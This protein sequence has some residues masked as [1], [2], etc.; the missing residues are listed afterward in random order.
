MNNNK[1][2]TINLK[3]YINSLSI[4]STSHKDI[5]TYINKDNVLE[6]TLESLELD[7]DK[8]NRLITNGIRD[9]DRFILESISFLNNVSL[10]EGNIFTKIIEGAKKIIKIILD[11]IVQ[12]FRWIGSLFKR[13]WNWITRKTK[14]EN[15]VKK[16]K[17]EKLIIFFRDKNYDTI[18][19]G[20]IEVGPNKLHNW[21]NLG[22]L[23]GLFTELQRR[24]A[25]KLNGREKKINEWSMH[26][27]KMITEYGE[28]IKKV[29]NGSI[30]IDEIKNVWIKRGD[31][32]V[33]E[34]KFQEYEKIFGKEKIK[35]I[36]YFA[37]LN[38]S[39]SFM[40]T[41]QVNEEIANAYEAYGDLFE[42]LGIDIEEWEENNFHLPKDFQKTFLTKFFYKNGKEFFDE[43]ILEL[44][45]VLTPQNI[46]FFEEYM[47]WLK[48]I[49]SIT[50]TMGPGLQTMMSSIET[51][52][53]Q[54]IRMKSALDEFLKKIETWDGKNHIM[55]QGNSFA[56]TRRSFVYDDLTVKDK[57][58]IVR[59]VTGET[60]AISYL[61]GIGIVMKQLFISYW[62]ALI[63]VLS[64]LDH[65]LLWIFTM[66]ELEAHRQ[67]IIDN[68]DWK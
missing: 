48:E 41:I 63:D 47:T 64:L 3:Q 16:K 54:I 29:S 38:A 7:I 33:Y 15:V 53:Q 49:E 59:N 56:D 35:S 67:E 9:N 61:L 10:E 2:I 28:F 39:Q 32:P 42:L 18:L 40:P 13:F 62:R 20:T 30:S 36:A 25:Q 60:K 68:G 11:K 55:V 65:D 6:Y 19:N 51:E 12:F 46:K 1:L 5:F 21:R 23:K 37:V 57:E 24:D 31:G 66:A 27:K 4:E 8:Y 22:D 50:K 26:I 43:G 44:K 58:K 45:T 14:E 34:Q 52:Q 17:W